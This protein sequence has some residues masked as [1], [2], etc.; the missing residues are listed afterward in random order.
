MSGGPLLEVRGLAK[1][2]G[3][4]PVLTEISFAVAPGELVG[5]TGENGS[6]KSTLLKVLA[7]RLRPDRGAWDLRGRLGYCP[8]EPLAF[9][10]LT[11]AENFRYFAAAHG[12]AD[13]RKAMDDLLARFHFAPYAARPVQELSAGTRQKL[14]L[15]LALL[16]DPDVLLLDEPY[17][18]FDWETYLRFWECAE[19]LRAAGRGLL[20]VSHLVY[21][22]DRFDRLL[23]LREGRLW[24]A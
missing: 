9:A 24:A 16:H 23:A 20:V 17:S 6:G 14:N 3:R 19:A 5:V 12:L 21:E 22:R 8:Q 10:R 11:V 15:A 4:Q 1:A 13:W 2:Y 7:G 18:G